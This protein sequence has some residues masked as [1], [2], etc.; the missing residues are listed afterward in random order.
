M[1]KISA[2]TA[3]CVE[4]RLSARRPAQACFQDETP[5][6]LSSWH[7]APQPLP[8]F[9]LFV[10]AGLMRL[11][12]LCIA[13]HPWAPFASD[14]HTCLHCRPA[15]AHGQRQRSVLD[16]R[17]ER[18]AAG[19]VQQECFLAGT[20]VLCIVPDSLRGGG[21]ASED[22]QLFIIGAPLPEAKQQSGC[23]HRAVRKVVC[24][25]RC[26]VRAWLPTDDNAGG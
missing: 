9:Y 20:G 25:M 1:G 13:G 16:A 10:W 22:A 5:T 23:P 26:F 24:A 21:E 19:A 7:G 11:P 18:G 15:R 17:E 8:L 4:P 14:T 3:S 2:I 6:R 12:E